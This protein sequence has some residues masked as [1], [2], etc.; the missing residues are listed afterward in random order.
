MRS[1]HRIFAALLF[2]MGFNK[3]I[4]AA[5]PPDII[6]KNGTSIITGMW[7]PKISQVTTDSP[8][9]GG[10][11][12]RFNNYD[13][14]GGWW[15]GFGLNLNNWGSTAATNFKGTK[16]HLRVAYRGLSAGHI[17][18]M[19]LKNGNT[20][21]NAIDIGG[22]VAAYTVVDV[23][24][25]SLS[26]GLNQEAITEIQ[27]NVSGAAT[28]T[29]TVFIDA[30]ELITQVIPP[31][32]ATIANIRAARL[33][34]GFN[35]TNWLEAHWLIPFNAYPQANYFT[36]AEIATL[37]GFGFKTIRMPVIFERLASANAPYTLNT[38]HPAFAI[39]DDVIAWAN[40]YNLNLIIDNHHANPDLTD[41]N[42]LTEIPRIKAVWTQ[43]ATRYA[44]LDPNRFFFEIYN[45]PNNIANTNVRKVMQAAIDA[46]RATG[47]VHTLLVGGSHWNSGADLLQVGIFSDENLIYTFHNYDPFLFTHQGFDWNGDG[48]P[49]YGPA[50]VVFPANATT[51]PTMK[52]YFADVK[53]WATTN[54]VPIFLGEFGTGGFADATSRCNWIKTMGEIIDAN[55]LPACYWDVRFLNGGFGFFTNSTVSSTICYCLALKLLQCTC[56]C[57]YCR[58]YRRLCRG[59]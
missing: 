31:K 25:S 51:I 2:L 58:F 23:P 43:L 26:A 45:E 28:G 15:D 14:G 55:Q 54:N 24:L 37:A 42:Y 35:L 5:D 34:L 7:S 20:L 53:T 47:D 6:Y 40:K 29:G 8:Y 10:Q 32:P 57:H 59:H 33:G 41:A 3:P 39:I 38:A 19:Q 48:S 21:G 16:T 50:G 9:E 36:E 56:S 44:S 1:F 30:I 46:I 18:Q 4:F 27:I 11:H 17:L 22:N 52:S 13:L 49:D 12:L